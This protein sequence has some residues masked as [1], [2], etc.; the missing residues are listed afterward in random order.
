VQQQQHGLHHP[1]AAPAVNS[2]QPEQPT[3]S[4]S[5]GDQGAGGGFWFGGDLAPSSLPS[6][7]Q[8]PL[9]SSEHL[10]PSCSG[11]CVAHLPSVCGATSG[12]VPKPPSAF[13]TAVPS[14][15]QQPLQ[16]YDMESASNI[17]PCSSHNM[18][19]SARTGGIPALFHENGKAS[20]L[21][22]PAAAGLPQGAP[23]FN[24]G[25]S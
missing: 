21:P 18:G 11:Q 3:S 15:Q 25:A 14:K 10:H 4:M 6:D 24:G 5:W 19:Q 8:L 23:G 20:Q 1:S 22:G 17:E 16:L 12:R 9:H 13:A 2:M 7:V